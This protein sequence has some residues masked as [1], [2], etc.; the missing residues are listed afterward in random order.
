MYISLLFLS[1]LQIMYLLPVFYRSCMY[2]YDGLRLEPVFRVQTDIVLSPYFF[3]SLFNFSLPN[4]NSKKWLL[5]CI[6]STATFMI[7]IYIFVPCFCQ[8]SYRIS[9][10][11]P[12][13]SYPLSDFFI[14]SL[15]SPAFLSS[16]GLFLL[17]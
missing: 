17:L 10:L 3:T 11:S 4:S 9:D 15:F 6:S 1:F 5:I 8:L 2:T 13:F 16:D 12:V 7:C 14:L